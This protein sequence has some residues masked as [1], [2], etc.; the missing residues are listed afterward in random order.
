CQ[1][2][3]LDVA[4]HDLGPVVFGY[5][6]QLPPSIVHSLFL[7]EG[8]RPPVHIEPRR[9][10]LDMLLPPVRPGARKGLS[11]EVTVGD[12]VRQTATEKSMAALNDTLLMNKLSPTRR[13]QPHRRKRGIKAA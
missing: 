12:L 6:G 10:G 11:Y 5:E 8:Q 2:V 1:G 4:G 3:R 9:A 7:T 13:R